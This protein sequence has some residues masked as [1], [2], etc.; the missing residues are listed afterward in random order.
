MTANQTATKKRLVQGLMNIINQCEDIENRSIIRNQLAEK[1]SVAFKNFCKEY[2]SKAGF[3]EVEECANVLCF[4]S[5]G[6]GAH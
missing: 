5:F 6:I 3:A 4:G 1:V 2:L